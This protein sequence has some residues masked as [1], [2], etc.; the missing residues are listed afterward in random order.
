[1]IV[2]IVAFPSIS[3]LEPKK[4]EI[5]GIVGLVV[6]TVM[7]DWNSV[8]KTTSMKIIENP[9]NDSYTVSVK[10]LLSAAYEKDE[11]L[12]DELLKIIISN[13]MENIDFTFSSSEVSLIFL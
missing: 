7:S 12:Y 2:R 6:Q 10:N 5:E 1:M 13:E 11:H 9:E 8:V 3:M 4:K